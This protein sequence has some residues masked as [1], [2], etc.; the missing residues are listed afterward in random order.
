MQTRGVR[1]AITLEENTKEEVKKAV[2]ELLDKMLK[3][4]ENCK[5]D[6]FCIN[7]IFFKH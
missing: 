3:E 4:S 5:S 1:G 2:V 7:F 6:I